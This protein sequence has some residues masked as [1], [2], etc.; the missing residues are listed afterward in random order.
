MQMS[1][2]VPHTATA[3]GDAAVSS[4]EI[5]QLRIPGIFG[6]WAAAALPMAALAWLVAPVVAD[7]FAGEGIVPMMKALIV[8]LTVG[9][10]WQFVLVAILI[11]REQRTLAGPGSAR[12]SGSAPH[13]ARAAAASGAGSG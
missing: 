8:C 7:R 4:V 2:S 9:L 10:I 5:P 12:H 11:G 6:V 1:I 13:E 3:R